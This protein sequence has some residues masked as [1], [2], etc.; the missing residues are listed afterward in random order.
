M[1][2]RAFSIV[3][4]LITLL[5]VSTS[6][7]SLLRYQWHT[8]QASNQQS[9]FWRA[10]GYLSQGCEHLKAKLS[11]PILPAPFDWQI[12]TKSRDLIVA[13]HFQQHH[14]QRQLICSTE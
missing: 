6:T 13:W 4:V 7:I 5:L 12:R 10:S 9:L 11:L 3:E 1:Q 8:A 14:Y 2:A